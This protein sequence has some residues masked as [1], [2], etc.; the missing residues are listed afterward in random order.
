MF[1]LIKCIV[2]DEINQYQIESPLVLSFKLGNYS[3]D[4]ITW[5]KLK[6]FNWN[7]SLKISPSIFSSTTKFSIYLEKSTR[8]RTEVIRVNGKPST[9]DSTRR[10]RQNWSSTQPRRGAN[11]SCNQRNRD[12]LR[13]HSKP[14]INQHHTTKRQD[15]PVSKPRKHYMSMEQESE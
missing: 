2:Y 7:S 5:S 3:L 4:W 13:R 10:R 8:Q 9:I 11:K 1:I 12:S 15:I 14:I 6:Y